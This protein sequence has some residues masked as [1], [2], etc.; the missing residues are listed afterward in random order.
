MVDI[1]EDRFGPPWIM[2]N[3]HKNG[4]P[5]RG[6]IIRNN[7]AATII[8]TGDTVEDHN[9]RLTGSDQLFVNPDAFD[10]HLRSDAAAVIDQGSSELAPGEDLDRVLRPGG[11][12]VDIGAYEY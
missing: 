9:Y 4:T 12:S 7:I 1:V 2:V 8:A 6:C 10:Y 11:Q 3:P 5:S